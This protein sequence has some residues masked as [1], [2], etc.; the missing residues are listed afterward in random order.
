ML[1]R[2]RYQYPEAIVWDLDG[3]I[4]DSAPDLA[5]ALGTLLQ[6]HDRPAPDIS[7]VRRMIG[8]GVAKLIERGFAASGPPI[9]AVEARSLMPE[10]MSI[11]CARATQL[12]RTYPGVRH[13]LTAFRD[14][15]VPQAVCTNKP[16]AVSRTILE[17]L[18]L[19]E[20]F[21]IV[22]GGDTLEYRKPHPLPLQYCLDALDANASA[23][24]LVG[25]SPVDVATAR[26]VEL[27]VG[28]VDH[29][30]ARQP[31]ETLGADF[32]I[33]DLA[34]LPETV[35]GRFSHEADSI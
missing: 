34:G 8:N 6:G 10:F 22:I 11:Y 18:G 15:G 9:A 17:D 28:I 21:E 33:N 30:Y 25:D 32:L 13:A 4:I 35:A 27:T 1:Q 2:S 16:E 14:A 23:S 29:G 5:G 7:S 20:F 31:V 12:T 24:L 26:A 3:T 19:G